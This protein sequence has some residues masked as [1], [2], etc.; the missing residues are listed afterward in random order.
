MQTQLE[1]VIR[2]VEKAIAG[3]RNVIRKILMAT[4]DRRRRRP[5]P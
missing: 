3:K 4:W 2:E 1:A 5:R